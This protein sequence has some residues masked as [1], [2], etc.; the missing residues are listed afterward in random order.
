MLNIECEGFE[1]SWIIKNIGDP[2]AYTLTTKEGGNVVYSAN[3]LKSI[4]WPGSVTV[5]SGGRYFS[6]Y[7]GT[8]I[9]STGTPYQPTAP[10]DIKEEPEDQEEH[11]EPNPKNAPQKIET[12][13]EAKN[14][15]TNP[16]NPES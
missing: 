10:L 4:R 12:D 6:I 8:A 14:P 16:E 5:C 11:P 15:E 13:T 9:K 7:I 1:F 3:V 2:Q